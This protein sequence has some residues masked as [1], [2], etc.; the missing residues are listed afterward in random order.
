M[1]CII[2]IGLLKKW[3]VMVFSEQNLTLNKLL[4][5]FTFCMNFISSSLKKSPKNY[6]SWLPHCQEKQKKRQKSGENGGF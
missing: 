5:L 2:D 4:K 3:D 1:G 6:I